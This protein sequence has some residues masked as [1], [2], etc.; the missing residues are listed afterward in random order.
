VNFRSLLFAVVIFVL[1]L[2]HQTGFNVL[3]NCVDEQMPR[4]GLP[5][6]ENSR[7]DTCGAGYPA[8]FPS[9]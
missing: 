3:G 4:H 6:N 8:A 5:R 2:D 1:T 9:A 7:R